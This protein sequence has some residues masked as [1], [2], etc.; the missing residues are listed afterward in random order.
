LAITYNDTGTGFGSAHVTFGGTPTSGSSN[1]VV[2]V[3]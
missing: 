1:L 3:F 2:T